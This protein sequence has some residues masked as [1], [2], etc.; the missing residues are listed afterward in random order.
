[1]PSF[2]TSSCKI[3]C[4]ERLPNSCSG[5]TAA[6]RSHAGGKRQQSNVAR[7]L[8]GFAQPALVARAR[9]G[10]APRKNLAAVLHEGLEHF[11]LLEVNKVHTVHAEPADLL[12][13]E[14]LPLA[15]ARAAWTSRPALSALP[16]LPAFATRR[17]GRRPTLRFLFF[18]HRCSLSSKKFLSPFRDTSAARLTLR[19][20]LFGRRRGATGRLAR[21]PGRL[22]LALALELLLAFQLFVEAHRQVL[23]D[24]VGNREAPLEFANQFALRALDLQIDVIAFP[25]LGDAIGHLARAPLLELFDLA[26]LFGA[27]VLERG[28]DFRDFLFRRGRP[29]DE[30]QIVQAFFHVFPRFSINPAALPFAHA[31]GKGRRTISQFRAGLKP[32]A[33]TVR[34]WA[35]RAC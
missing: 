8:D 19:R 28:D 3:I 26:A 13:A 14:E 21:T 34:P 23:D 35:E 25:M 4:I 27:S 33:T 30:N 5:Q 17:S 12:F 20:G 6:G 15:L 1:M 2:S 18:S 9:A 24:H 31:P 10:H 7:A 29:A 16:A 11:H 32:G 22:A